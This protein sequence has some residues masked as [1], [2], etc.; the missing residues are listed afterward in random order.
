MH[1][2]QFHILNLHVVVIFYDL[3]NMVNCS[4]HSSNL[5]FMDFLDGL[6]FTFKEFLAFMADGNFC[7][8]RSIVGSINRR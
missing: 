2:L 8:P 1:K 5:F 4:R 7:Y 3:G 6:L